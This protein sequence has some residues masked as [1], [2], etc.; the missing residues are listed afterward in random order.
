MADS[1]ALVL[2]D[3]HE[4]IATLTLNRP[5]KLNAL[6]GAM[7]VELVERL[8]EVRADYSVRSVVLT[9]AGRA[10]CAGDDLGHEERFKFGYPDLQTRL[11]VG[12][13]SAVLQLL[14]LRKP[15]VGMV[16]GYA[17]GAGMD[18]A[19]AC[20][21]RVAEEQTRMA[22][23][24]VKRG[25]GGGCS[26]LLPRFV[27]LGKATELLLLGDNITMP[28]A[29]ALNLVTRVVSEPELESSTYELAGRLAKGPTGSY[30]SIKNARNQG[31]GCDPVKGLEYQI[32][33]NVELM[34][35]KDAREG[36]KSFAEGRDP[37][38]TGEW[39]DLQYH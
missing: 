5:E 25:M 27:G 29:L 37:E 6:T 31:L 2:L 3:K 10:F 23:I 30:G 14:S 9:G 4:G 24:F 26:Y 33:A 28:E 35:Y 34:F 15:V 38:F 16:R 21:F 11:K 7:I 36:P 8:D 13:P 12:Y 39:V 18:V 17:V 22:A 19:L 20:D 32:M 1:S